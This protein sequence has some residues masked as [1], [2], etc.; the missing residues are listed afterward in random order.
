MTGILRREETHRQPRESHVTVEAGTEVIQLPVEEHQGLLATPGAN[1]HGPDSS[2]RPSERARPCWH[3]DFRV[4]ASRTVR[5]SISVA[6]SHSVH[7][8]LSQQSRKL[9]CYSLYLNIN[10]KTY[11][12]CLFIVKPATLS[13]CSFDW[14]GLSFL[15]GYFSALSVLW[16]VI[17]F[18]T[19]SQKER[20]S[21]HKN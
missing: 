3:L 15:V 18:I 17:L 13:R 14:F 8:T 7:S 11:K 16:L 12:V 6:A 20:Y 1:K 5:E 9:T 10:P 19:V 4:L 2:L 21:S